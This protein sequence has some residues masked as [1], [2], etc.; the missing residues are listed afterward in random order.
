M[1][2]LVQE[3]LTEKLARTEGTRREVKP[4]MTLGGGLK[5]LRVENRRI[6]KL[7]EAEFEKIEPEDR[8]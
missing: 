7:I 1:K 4:W 5:H 2:H 3:A 8:V 6:E